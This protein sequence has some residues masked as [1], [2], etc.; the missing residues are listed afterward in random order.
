MGHSFI[1]LGGDSITVFR[2]LNSIQDEF[3]ADVSIRELFSNATLSTL[4]SNIESQ[5]KGTT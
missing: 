1:S 2:I 3:C 5:L 4:A